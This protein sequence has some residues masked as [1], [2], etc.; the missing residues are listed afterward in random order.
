MVTLR[1]ICG[2]SMVWMAL[3]LGCSLANATVIF[4]G[5]MN[6]T[7]ANPTQLG[8]LSR[9]GVPQDWSGGEAF[10][11]VINTATSYHYTTLDLDLTALEAGYD[12]GEFIQINF[13]STAATTFLSAY[14]D[15]YSPAN[16]G[17][18]WLGDTGFSGNFP[19]PNPLFFQVIVQSP[20]H[21]VLLLNETTTNG[22]LNLPGNVLVEAF[23]D[24]EYTDLTPRA[25]VPEP[26]TWLLLVCGMTLLAARRR[27]GRGAAAERGEAFPR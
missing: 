5:T 8:R 24:T 13:D 4:S 9:N 7:A 23:A 16:P 22:G 11:G 18:T 6:L 10:P 14:V 1:K 21:M 25:A 17:G 2:G 15:S 27:Y 26:G 20:H 3:F 19:P 12:Y